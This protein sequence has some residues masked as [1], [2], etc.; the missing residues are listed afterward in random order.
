LYVMTRNATGKTIKTKKIKTKI[1][2]Y[3]FSQR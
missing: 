1:I 2:A 3:L